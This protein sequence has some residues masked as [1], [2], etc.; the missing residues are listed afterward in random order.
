MSSPEAFEGRCLAAGSTDSAEG[1]T[2]VT[3][4]HRPPRS[5]GM[6]L[7]AGMDTDAFARVVNANKARTPATIHAPGFEPC[8]SGAGG[9]IRTHTVLPCDV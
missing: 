4:S 5:V 6:L 7:D 3:A 2:V 1:E 9:G 8:A